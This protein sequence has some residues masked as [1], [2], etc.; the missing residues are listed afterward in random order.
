[1]RPY[2]APALGMCARGQANRPLVGLRGISAIMRQVLLHA[3]R[4]GIWLVLPLWAASAAATVYAPSLDSANWQ[5]QQSKLSCRLKQAIPHY[6]DAVFEARAGGSQRF[7]LE[8]KRNLME[9][10]FARLV[11]KAPFWNPDLSPVSL[12]P[13]PVGN[14][15]RPVVLDDALT[16]ELLRTLA[17]GL[18]PELERP[19]S[20]DPEITVSIGLLPVRFRQAYG[21]YQDCMGQLLPV[22]REQ[23]STTVL[24]FE[25]E[26]TGLTTAARGQ[27]DKL[28]LHAKGEKGS[29]LIIDALS[30]DTPRRLENVRLAR[31]RADIVG[32]YLVS[33]GIDQ[34]RIASSFRGERGT[35]RQAVVTVRLGASRGD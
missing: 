27:L 31:E 10:G 28:L 26:Q 33:N 32:A 29:K 15:S 9:V 24:A 12:G 8:T 7:F 30:I 23:V 14:G 19:S 25:L 22:S 34:G 16:R 13:V 2:A 1:M 21:Q 35:R 4:A 3:A 6:G 11:A 5:V 18:A 20:A 17:S